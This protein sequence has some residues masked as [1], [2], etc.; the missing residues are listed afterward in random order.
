MAVA[1]G[2]QADLSLEPTCFLPDDIII[3]DVCVIGGGSS[4]TYTA[5]RLRDSNKSV[6]VLE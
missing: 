5:T 3:R 1:H 4:G 6:V 2:V